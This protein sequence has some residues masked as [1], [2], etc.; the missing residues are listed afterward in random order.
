MP[1]E[2]IFP[3]RRAEGAYGIHLIRRIAGWPFPEVLMRVEPDAQTFSEAIKRG[4]RAFAGRPAAT[5]V[6]GFC[7]TER[8]TGERHFWYS[9]DP[10]HVLAEDG[11]RLPL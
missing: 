6:D 11:E 7:I 4:K 9:D 1:G 2:N 5:R 10:D 3:L 8:A